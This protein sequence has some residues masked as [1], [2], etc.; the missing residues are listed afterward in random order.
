MNKS[1]KGFINIILIGIVIAV[2]VAGAVAYFVIVKKPTSPITQQTTTPPVLAKFLFSKNCFVPR[3]QNLKPRW[4][5]TTKPVH[6]EKDN[7]IYLD[8]IYPTEISRKHYY[9]ANLT[10]KFTQGTNIRLR[11]NSFISLNQGCDLTQFNGFLTQGNIKT[12]SRAFSRPEEDLER[13]KASGEKNSG[14]ELGDL[15]L[16]YVIRLDLDK[17]VN[18]VQ[19]INFLNSLEIIETA[20]LNPIPELAS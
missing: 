10:I 7:K 12:I 9:L 16:F 5:S 2:I 3:N 6:F 19:F 14:E 18:F 17:G 4:V 8:S 1:Q 13:E 11:N 20:Y 15:N